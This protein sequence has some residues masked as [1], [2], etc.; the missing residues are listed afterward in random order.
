MADQPANKRTS[1]IRLVGD[2]ESNFSI[3]SALKELAVFDV[4]NNDWIVS[5]ETIGTT[6]TELKVGGSRKV[7]RKMVFFQLQSSGTIYFGDSNTTCFFKAF[8]NQLM[9]LPA[10]EDTEIWLKCSDADL[11]VII[12]EA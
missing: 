4:L 3:V 1:T 12:G 11:T 2:D 9:A 7:N 8:K 5:S 6:E 10:G